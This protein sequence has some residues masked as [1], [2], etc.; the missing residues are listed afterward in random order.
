VAALRAGGPS[1]RTSY[2]QTKNKIKKVGAFLATKK[3]TA[4]TPHQPRKSPHPHHQNTTPK[5]RFSSKPQ[6]KRTLHHKTKI[7]SAK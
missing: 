1:G 3:V 2:T 7:I 5:T 6:Q 4:K